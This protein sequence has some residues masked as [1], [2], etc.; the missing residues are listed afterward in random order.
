[1]HGIVVVPSSA[2]NKAVFFKDI[3]DDF[4]DVIVEGVGFV[5]LPVARVVGV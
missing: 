2:P 3:D 5:P 1:M 4:W